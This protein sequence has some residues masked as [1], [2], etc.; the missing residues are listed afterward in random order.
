MTDF[1]RLKTIGAG[2]F[3]K[4]ILVQHRRKLTYYAMKVMEKSKVSLCNHISYSYYW[5]YFAQV[6]AC[7]QCNHVIYEKETL[8]AVDCQ[9]VVKLYHTFKVSV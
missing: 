8:M 3:G 2:T 9:F 1:L 6:V 5:Y 7:R 4:V